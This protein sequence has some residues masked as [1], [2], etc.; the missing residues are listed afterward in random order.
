MLLGRVLQRW[1]GSVIIEQPMMI[2]A[3]SAGTS[4]VSAVG[5]WR[6]VP[7]FFVIII[8]PPLPH[9]ALQQKME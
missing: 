6:R 3:V 1:E 2:A 9:L 7:L 4:I 5:C 8:L